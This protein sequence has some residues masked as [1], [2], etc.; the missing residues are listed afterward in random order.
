[1]DVPHETGYHGSS[2]FP[3]LLPEHLLLR[4]RHQ[5]QEGSIF[6]VSLPCVTGF[7]CPAILLVVNAVVFVF[8]YVQPA[9]YELTM[10]QLYSE[11]QVAVPLLSC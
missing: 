7:H 2:L 5:C 11:V 8:P 9:Y 6:S 10:E 3:V 1:M 4:A